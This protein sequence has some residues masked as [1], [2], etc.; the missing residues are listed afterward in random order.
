MTE[1]SSRPGR[2]EITQMLA[3]A[4]PG[5]AALF[6]QLLPAVYDELRA[7]AAGKLRYERDGHT[8]NATALV[9]EAYLK[10]VD[11]DRVE[12]QSRGHF[13]AV[14]SEAMR[15]VL[16]NYARARNA[17][18]RGGKADHLKL[19]DVQVFEKAEDADRIEALDDALRR[20]EGFDP[21][22]AKVVTYRYFGGLMNQEIAD[23]LGV[24]EVTVRRSWVAAKAWLRAEIADD[25]FPAEST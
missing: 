24:S 1:A 21:R 20:L 11:H 25:L 23:V 7:M 22:G 8:L 15:R 9:H 10:L 12:W 17:Q 3:Q 19:D 2:A 14:A 18:K 4:R 6:E 5:D 13:F 16:V